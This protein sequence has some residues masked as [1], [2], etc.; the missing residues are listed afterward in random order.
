METDTSI[1]KGGSS[2]RSRRY[3]A[4]RWDNKKIFGMMGA[5]YDEDGR[6]DAGKIRKQQ[7]RRGRK[8]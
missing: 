2:D 5:S 8:I 4:E 1:E 3:V 6:R 7:Y